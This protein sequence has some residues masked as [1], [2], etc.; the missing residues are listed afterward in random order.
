MEIESVDVVYMVYVVYVG[1]SFVAAGSGRD[2]LQGLFGGHL[3]GRGAERPV[4]VGTTIPAPRL[5]P[6]QTNAARP[7]SVGFC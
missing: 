6:G 1:C 5:E 3:L 4:S 2:G 7:S